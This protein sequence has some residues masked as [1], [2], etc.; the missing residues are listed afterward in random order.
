MPTVYILGAG[1]SAGYEGSF[2]GERSPVAENFFE[3]AYRVRNIHQCAERNFGDR[4]ITYHHFEKFVEQHYG[5]PL[6]RL[7][8]VNLDME[9]ILTFLDIEIERCE[10][11]GKLMELKAARRDFLTLMALTFEKVLYGEPCPYHARLASFLRPGDCVIS[12]NYDLL[13]DNALIQHCPVWYLDDG[14]GLPGFRIIDKHTFYPVN[15][16]RHS[17]VHLLKMHGSFNWMVCQD[18]GNFYIFAREDAYPHSLIY[19]RNKEYPGVEEP[20]DHN[21]DWIIVPPTLKK[22]F[23]GKVLQTVWHKAYKAL[24]HADNIV[25]I[26]YSLP[27]TDFY[28][29]RLFHQAASKNLKLKQVEIVDKQN[30]VNPDLLLEKYVP[31][32]D[33]G[34]NRVKVFARFC[35]IGE[36]VKS[37]LDPFPSSLFVNR[38]TLKPAIILQS[39]GKTQQWHALPEVE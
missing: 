15:L 17:K 37:R 7:A 23:S 27:A 13:I 35:N 22:D 2:L 25:I 12:F 24:L 31:I 20:P 1:A 6:E 26:G 18:C 4:H 32:F 34:R 29:K 28:V 30:A 39:T 14:Y 3:I 36:Y 16:K 9:D 11:P 19:R 10:I 33:R 5:T 38:N 8:E 21:L